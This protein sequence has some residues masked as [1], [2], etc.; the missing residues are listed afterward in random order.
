MVQIVCEYT[1]EIVDILTAIKIMNTGSHGLW[2]STLKLMSS[3][4]NCIHNYENDSHSFGIEFEY[5][6]IIF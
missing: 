6:V 1:L 5:D 2:T 3:F 4:S